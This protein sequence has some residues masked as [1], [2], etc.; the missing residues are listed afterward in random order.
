MN[1]RAL[2][3][4]SA[5]SLITL[6]CLGGWHDAHGL[7]IDDFTTPQTVVVNS[8]ATQADNQAAGAGILGGE[9]DM[10]VTL[11]GGTGLTLDAAL[12]ALLYDQFGVSEGTGLIVWDGVDGDIA[13][14]PVGL[15]GVDFTEAGV[16]DAIG[17]TVLSSDAPLTAI[18]VAYTNEFNASLA[19][20]SLPGNIP[21]DPQQVLTIAFTDFVVIS[22]S[23]ADFTD[24]G[25]FF[26]F[27]GGSGNPGG[28]IQIGSISTVSSGVPVPELETGALLA[29]G[30]LALGAIRRRTALGSSR[31]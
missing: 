28:T 26:M 18:T 25:A 19:T 29:L 5:L 1:N 6:T 9:R 27:I 24:I 31:T 17:M 23:G 30:L 4:R 21:P 7:L 11:V 13:L 8:P 20:F 12:G 22:G 15:G 14:D 16:M 3:L 2:G 10:S